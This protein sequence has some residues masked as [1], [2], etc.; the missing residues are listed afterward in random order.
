[1]SDFLYREV[2]A[3]GRRL[4]RLGLS[5]SFGLDER[6]CR[7]ALERIQYVFWDPRRKEFTRALRDVLAREREP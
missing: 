1:M 2:P 3:L 5:G 4:Y 6:G 7:E